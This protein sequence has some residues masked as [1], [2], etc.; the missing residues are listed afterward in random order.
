MAV[1]LLAFLLTGLFVARAAHFYRLDCE[2]AG[3]AV[4]EHLSRAPK[5][6]DFSIR[7][8][9]WFLLALFPLF[10]ISAV[11]YDVGTDYFY[12]YIPHFYEIVNGGDPYSEWGFTWLNKIIA[13]FTHNA[14]GVI[15]VTSFIYVFIAVRTVIHCS[16][17]PALSVVVLF[18]SCIY[19]I[20][21]NNIR[22]GIAAIII[23]SATPYMVKPGY[24]RFLVSVFFAYLFHLAALLML[25]PFLC[26]NIKLIRKYFLIFAISATALLPLLCVVLAA[27]LRHTKYYY[28]FVSDYNDNMPTTRNVVYHLFFFILAMVVLYKDRMKDK[29]GFV[30][31]FMQFCAFWV[32]ATSIFIRVSEMISRVTVFFSVYQLLLIPHMCVKE[33]YTGWD[34][35]IAGTYIALY[36]YYL[37]VFIVIRGYHQVLPYQ[38]VF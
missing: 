6:A 31:L 17:M 13:F 14:Q 8:I 5:F 18:L 7:Y 4:G 27:I 38:W 34:Y 16:E 20:E 10:F 3:I 21:L 19:F 24:I 28:F 33:K 26:V 12:T 36:G 25:V 37:L 9:L 29:Y 23:L 32:S 15:V 35:A 22:Q 11:R 2:R 30:L 1:Y